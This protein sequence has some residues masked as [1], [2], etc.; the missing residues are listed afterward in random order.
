LPEQ[1]LKIYADPGHM[2]QVL[3]NLFNNAIYAIVERHG[4]E[5]G[6][7]GISGSLNTQGLV[8]I[9]VQDNGGGISPENQ[10]KIF[11]PFFTTKPVGKGTGLGL[12]VC[13]GLVENMG[14]TME[15]SSQQGTGTTFTLRFPSR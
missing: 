3:L 14:G 7:L 13:F 4:S 11:S 6:R 1:P 2:Q 9:R 15:V 10:K 12:S 5:G 8:E